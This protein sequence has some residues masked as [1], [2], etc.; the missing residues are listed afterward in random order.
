MSLNIKNPEVERLANELAKELGVTKTEAIRLALA[1]KV[2]ILG[3]PEKKKKD[4][5]AFNAYLEKMWAKYP[6]IREFK[7]S[8]E[9]D[10]ALFE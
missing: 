3:L 5:S 10:D 7:F 6:A 8:K 9:E 1:E 2:Q 4:H